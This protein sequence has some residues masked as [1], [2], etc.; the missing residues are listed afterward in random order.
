[1]G[2]QTRFIYVHV[3]P[4]YYISTRLAGRN[5]INL[6]LLNKCSVLNPIRQ[7]VDRQ[8]ILKWYFGSWCI[9]IYIVSLKCPMLSYF[10]HYFLKEKNSSTFV[11]FQQVL[12]KFWVRIITNFQMSS[13]IK[14]LK[15]VFHG[16]FI[17]CCT[18]TLFK[19]PQQLDYL[20]SAW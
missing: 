11:N 5:P 19:L 10:L 4:K 17:N 20:L 18:V 8:T 16:A 3:A 14:E 6:Y 13:K 9:F 15:N 2:V 1:M 12:L 7:F